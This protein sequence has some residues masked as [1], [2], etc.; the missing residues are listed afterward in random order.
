MS[1]EKRLGYNRAMPQTA[2]SVAINAPSNANS[3]AEV[4]ALKQ[5]IA[6]LKKQLA[7]FQQQLFGRKSEKRTVETHPQ[8]LTMDDL[9]GD[10]VPALPEVDK[11]TITYERGK[12]RKHR[13]EDC[14]ADSGLRFGPEVSITHIVIEPPELAGPD[15]VRQSAA[16]RQLARAG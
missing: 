11:E 3:N 15:A 14:V 4:D 1:M 10:P 5:E 13:P 7:W 6:A 9:L 16:F 8:Q 2:P 12:A